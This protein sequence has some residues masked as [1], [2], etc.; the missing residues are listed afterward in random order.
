CVD[1]RFSSTS[2][3][4]V[5][6]IS[7]P[8]RMKLPRMRSETG[9]SSAGGGGVSTAD[10]V[11]PSISVSGPGSF[12]WVLEAFFAPPEDSADSLNAMMVLRS[13]LWM[14]GSVSGVEQA[15]LQEP[16]VAHQGCDVEP[17]P[18]S[19]SGVDQGLANPRPRVLRAG[20]GA[21]FFF[22][23]QAARARKQQA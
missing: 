8:N 20:G 11:A 1:W 16:G 14:F 23:V 4:T 9:R 10:P 22:A 5:A 19:V 6:M 15:D 7:R 21:E 18:A 2:S 17:Q 3:T 12:F 13:D